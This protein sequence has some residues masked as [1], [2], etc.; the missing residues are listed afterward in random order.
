PLPHASPLFPYPTLFRSSPN[1][2]TLI[3]LGVGAAYGYSVAVL[4][5]PET[6]G[7][8]LYFET[9]AVVVVLVLLGQVLELRARGATSQ[10]I[11][12]LRSDEHTSELQSPYD[13][14]C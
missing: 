12:R 3:A 10:A 1:M 11:R 13:L 6:L 4:L 14:V 7:H 5:L 8:D 2:F 9:A